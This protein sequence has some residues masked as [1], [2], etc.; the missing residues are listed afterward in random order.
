MEKGTAKSRTYYSKNI[1]SA[2][3]FQ[4]RSE[5]YLSKNKKL[6]DSFDFVLMGDPSMSK[7]PKKFKDWFFL[8]LWE[9][10]NVKRN[11]GDSSHETVKMP[12]WISNPGKIWSLS[13]WIG[14]TVYLLNFSGISLLRKCCKPLFQFSVGLFDT[15][16]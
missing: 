13:V 15:V 3:H 11:F 4:V 2:C 5:W 7:L 6:F 14:L 1:C 10:A 16:W 12:E 8:F 9:L